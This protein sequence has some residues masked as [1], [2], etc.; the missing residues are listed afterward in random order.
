M[1]WADGVISICMIA[2]AMAPK[3]IG[4]IC[5]DCTVSSEQWMGQ[6]RFQVAMA[7]GCGLWLIL[8]LRHADAGLAP[9]A[10]NYLAGYGM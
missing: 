3:T 5:C 6:R 2:W 4:S 7:S 9:G 10:V 1:V 8:V